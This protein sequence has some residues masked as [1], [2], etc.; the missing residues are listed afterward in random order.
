MTSINLSNTLFETYEKS[1]FITRLTSS[2]PF[3]DARP[4]TSRIPNINGN[5]NAITTG[6]R[7]TA[8]LASPPKN[9]EYLYPTIATAP[10]KNC[11]DLRIKSL[12]HSCI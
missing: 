7:F 1:P 4:E 12:N 5:E 6:I 3:R 11:V 2:S 10:E 9:K 8:W